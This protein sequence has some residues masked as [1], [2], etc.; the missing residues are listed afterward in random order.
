MVRSCALV[1]IDARPVTVEV[2]V[3]FGLPKY[4]VVGL[5]HASVK[6]GATRIRAALASVGQAMP[7]AVVT[8]NLAPADERKLGAAFDLPIALG[9]LAGDKA[10]DLKPLRDLLVLGEL[11]LDGS[12]RPVRGAL[13][14]A[15]LARELGLRGVLAPAES[16]EEA[17]VVDGIEVY[18]AEH[19][20]ELLVAL[21]GEGELER[22]VASTAAVTGTKPTGADLSDVRGQVIARRAVEVAVAGGHNA[23]LVGPPGIGK[24]MLARRIPTVLPPMSHDE[25]LEVTRIHSAVGATRGLIRERPFRAAHHTISAPAMIGGG[26][27]VRP[28]EV[29]LA[30]R[31]V[32][33]VD[34]LP[35]LS[36]SVLE[37]L[38]QPLED[39][40]VTVSRVQGTFTFPCSF[41]LVASANPCPC[42]WL[43]SADRNCT[44]SPSAIARYRSRLSGPLLDRIDLQVYVPNVSLHDMRRASPGESSARVRERVMAARARQQHRLSGHGIRTNAELSPRALRDTCRLSDD[45]ERA[46]V[47]L[48]ETRNNMTGRAIDRLIKVAQT[49]ADL[50]G[51]DQISAGCIY[52]AAGFRALDSDP[53]SASVPRAVAPPEPA[54]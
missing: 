24:T 19:F 14:A 27:P 31:G 39:R 35:E 53:G 25:M 40:E 48:Y 10:I 15:L 52:E 44:C 49:V 34:E 54:G 47:R 51:A 21:T 7:H 16:A 9:V 33:F 17:A 37:G 1:G 11:G 4:N 38:R 50:E 23:L 12:L 26:H 29:S 41:L 46:L 13:A 18:G 32:L 20:G 6:E 28:G 22:A 2:D 3:A 30:H 36:R 43:G 5:A 8:V 42:G 45:A